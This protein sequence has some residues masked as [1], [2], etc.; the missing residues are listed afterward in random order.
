MFSCLLCSAQI[1]L[2]TLE[3]ELCGIVNSY[4]VFITN[5]VIV[6]REHTAQPPLWN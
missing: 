4:S 2:K 6:F 5:S 1:S 3:L